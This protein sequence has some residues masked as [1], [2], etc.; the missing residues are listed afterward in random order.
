MFAV[1]GIVLGFLSFLPCSGGVPFLTPLTHTV[2]L[3]VGAFEGVVIG[4][5]ATTPCTG[6]L[7]LALD[8]ARFATIGATF[9]SAATVVVLLSRHVLSRFAVKWARDV[10]LV[11]GLTPMSEPLVQALLDEANPQTDCDPRWAGRGRRPRTRVV[12]LYD[13]ALNPLVADVAASGA[14]A[15]VGNATDPA[16]LR[17]ILTHRRLWRPGERVPSLRRLFAVTERQHVNLRIIDAATRAL[18]GTELQDSA[19]VIPRLT[20][21]LD[22]AR[23]ALDF[24]LAHPSADHGFIDAI[25]TDELVA[26][27]LVDDLASTGCQTLLIQG[28]SGLV[29]A[30]LDAI[31]WRAWSMVDLARAERTGVTVT[32]VPTHDLPLRI[33]LVGKRA[34]HVLEE[35]RRSGPPTSAA[36]GTDVVE[37]RE[38]YWQDSVGAVLQGEPAGSTALVICEA[39]HETAGA[40]A[41]LARMYPQARVFALD[42]EARGIESLERVGET[43]RALVTRFG[44]MLHRTILTSA[45]ESRMAAPEDGWTRLARHLH[46]AYIKENGS[47]GRPARQPWGDTGEPAGQRAPEFVREDNLR[48][49]RHLL[50]TWWCPKS[51]RSWSPYGPI[52]GGVPD[53]EEL[54][55]LARSEHERWV[56][57]R[58][59]N[60]WSGDIGDPPE[61]ESED[62]KIARLTQEDEKRVNRNI[63]MWETGIPIDAKGTPIR[64][65]AIPEDS[66]ALGGKRGLHSWNKEKVVRRS[67]EV[68]R[69]F[70]IVPVRSEVR[71]QRVGEVAARQLTEAHTWQSS[72]GDRL[73]GEVGDWIVS[74]PEGGERTVAAVEFEKLYEA[75][76]EGTFCRRGLV[77][78]RQ[79]MAREYV[80]SLEGEATA[81]PGDWIVTDDRCNSWPVPDHVFRLSYARVERPLGDPQTAGSESAERVRPTQ[82]GD[83]MPEGKTYPS[84]NRSAECP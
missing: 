25:S 71:Y 22:D 60:G 69:A 21:R 36:L 42:P 8:L 56:K 29:T 48:Q 44:P 64:D 28:D 45:G 35:W 79:T 54:T 34:R 11:V 49:L 37:V 77:T 68:L 46:G 50:A 3:F 63:R 47:D 18:D 52:E 40:A 55:M 74:S 43:R 31:A 53:D 58:I 30:L 1:V 41:R 14:I 38:E 82:S 12:V 66:K 24:R 61:D 4:P 81:E 2:L 72:Q 65:R 84:H 78:A 9:T 13:D 17:P 15:I 33:V 26:R 51:G 19:R 70:G 23:E 16:I 20:A 6:A 10:D 80:K 67:L 7:P 39:T 59:E 62:A 5:Q 73:S 32:S 76:S 83:G 75:I 27:E 57:L